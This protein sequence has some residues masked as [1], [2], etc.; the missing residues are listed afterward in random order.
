MATVDKEVVVRVMMKLLDK[1]GNDPRLTSRILREKVEEKLKLKKGDLKSKR[2]F[3]KLHTLKWW[4]DNHG[5]ASASSKSN[6]GSSGTSVPKKAVV[7]NEPTDRPKSVEAPPRNEALV[8]LTKLARAVGK[9]PNFFKPM[10]DMSDEKRI[11][12]MRRV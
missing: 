8:M 12:R 6:G 11:S 5:G 2:E 4:Y 7:K 10:M 1:A 9:G 3:M